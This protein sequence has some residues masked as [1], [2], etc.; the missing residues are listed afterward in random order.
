MNTLTT[1]VLKM[2]QIERTSMEWD[3]LFQ[4]VYAELM[5]LIK[6]LSYSY[7]YHLKGDMA[8]AESEAGLLLVST[9]ERFEY[10]GFEF[11]SFFKKSLHNRLRDMV[12]TAKAQKNSIGYGTIGAE[13]DFIE[14]GR[15]YER[16]ISDSDHTLDSVYD[17]YALKNPDHGQVLEIMVKYSASF[18]NKSDLTDAL[19]AHYGEATYNGTIQ[20]RVSRIRE[21]FRKYAAEHGFNF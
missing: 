21:S 7:E 11:K 10:Q 17:A 9:I 1:K 20:K 12:S 13:I 18:Y 3:F 15:M 6:T 16:V 2:Q 14:A 4:E 19:A 5:D 8:A